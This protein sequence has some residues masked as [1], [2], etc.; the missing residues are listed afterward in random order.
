MADHGDKFLHIGAV[1]LVNTRD[2]TLHYAI[3]E[4]IKFWTFLTLLRSAAVIFSKG[5]FLYKRH[6]KRFKMH[7]IYGSSGADLDR[8]KRKRVTP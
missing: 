8:T 3:E 4:E 5:L 2:H 7:A 1:T 6:T